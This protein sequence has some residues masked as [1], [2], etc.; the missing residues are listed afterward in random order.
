MAV[1]CSRTQVVR[2]LQS[3][4]GPGRIATPERLR[5]S[6]SR[7]PVL[8]VAIVRNPR[9]RPPT[10]FPPSDQI[11]IGTY[12][13]RGRAYVYLRHEPDNTAMAPQFADR[14][15]TNRSPFEKNER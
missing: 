14:F 13:P 7:R 8:I 2:G 12:T 10:V 9:V 1:V 6:V 3:A 4:P 5:A 11:S 15:L